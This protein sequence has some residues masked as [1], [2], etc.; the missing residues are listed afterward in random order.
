MVCDDNT[1]EAAGKE[2]ERLLGGIPVIK[3]DPETCMPMRSE[4]R[5]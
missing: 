5:R 3:L 2:V 4:L 1:Y